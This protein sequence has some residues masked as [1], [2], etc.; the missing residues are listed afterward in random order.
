ML[1]VLLQQKYL[2][3]YIKKVCSM[4]SSWIQSAFPLST[5]QCFS[6]QQPLFHMAFVHTDTMSMVANWPGEECPG[7]L[8]E[9]LVCGDVE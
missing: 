1:P 9:A 7:P 6:I 4:S 2:A 8:M 5:I 3:G